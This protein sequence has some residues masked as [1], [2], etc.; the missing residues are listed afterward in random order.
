MVGN[1]V[2]RFFLLLI[3]EGDMLEEVRKEIEGVLNDIF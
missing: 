1:R 2:I 3:I